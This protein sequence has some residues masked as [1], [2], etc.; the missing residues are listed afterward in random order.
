MIRTAQFVLLLALV[1][2]T[3]ARA[4]TLAGVEMPDTVKVDGKTLVLNGIGLREAFW[5]KAY[6]GALYL[7]ERTS[8][9][10][11]VLD[12]SQLK[13]VAIKFLRNIDRS[14]LASGWAEQLQKI[15]GK[16]MEPSIAK[17]TSLIGDVKEGD[18]MSFTWRAGTGVEVSLSGEVRGSVAGDAFARTLFMLW[19]GPNPGDP[20]L[21][22]GMLG[23]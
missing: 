17:F 8:D 13:Q 4:A 16:T 5:V 23:K 7:E 2:V 18:T 14:S 21:K 3:S 22:R 12:S 15:G 9:A 19:F 20:N 10:Q 6:V 1:C 11:T